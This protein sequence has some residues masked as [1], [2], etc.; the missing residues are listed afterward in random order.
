MP[1]S[2]KPRAPVA[3]AETPIV[4][5]PAIKPTKVDALLALLCQDGGVTLAEMRAATGWQAHSVRGALSGTIA[6]RRG[7]AVTSRMADEQRRYFIDGGA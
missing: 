6:R 5:A 3:V 1:K 4:E 7:L 2:R